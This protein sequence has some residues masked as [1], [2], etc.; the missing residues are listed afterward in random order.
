MVASVT[1]PV[2]FPPIG[3]TLAAFAVGALAREAVPVVP[4]VPDAGSVHNPTF[5]GSSAVQPV[6]VERS[7]RTASRHGW[8][9]PL[10]SVLK[11]LVVAA[12]PHAVYAAVVRHHPVAPEDAS[13]ARCVPVAA[14]ESCSR[15]IFVHPRRRSSSCSVLSRASS[16]KAMRTSASN[17][18]DKDCCCRFWLVAGVKLLL[19]S[20]AS[21]RPQPRRLQARVPR[22]QRV[23]P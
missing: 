8:Q 12:D 1:T 5:L 2:T 18:S 4:L 16:A 10:P 22:R 17:R 20:G 21:R 14:P 15:L 13:K 19:P 9:V 11:E 3:P 6:Q 7:R 23:D